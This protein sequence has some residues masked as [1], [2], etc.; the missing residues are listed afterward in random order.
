MSFLPPLKERKTR[1]SVSDVS[2]ISEV[3]QAVHLGSGKVYIWTAGTSTACSTWRCQ[4]PLAPADSASF[5]NQRDTVRGCPT[6]LFCKS[7]YSTRLKFLDVAETNEELGDGDADGC[8]TLGGH[9]LE[10]DSS[11]DAPDAIAVLSCSAGGLLGGRA[12]QLG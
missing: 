9:E 5:V 2:V 4:S 7:C 1:V 11:S 6:S 3:R 8:D 10:S 12:G